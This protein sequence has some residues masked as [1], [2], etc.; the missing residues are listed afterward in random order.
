MAVQTFA[1][2]AHYER[3]PGERPY[4]LYLN[5]V[6][7]VA[8]LAVLLTHGTFLFSSTRLTRWVLPPIIFGWWGVDLFFV[9]S[10]F[11]ITGILLSTRAAPN[12]AT[13]FYAR[14]VLRIFPIYYLCLA[15]LWMVSAHSDW[16]GTMLP[17]SSAADRA[18]Y[19]FYFQNWIPLWHS[20]TLK[21][22]LLGHFWSLAVEEQFY[23]IWPWVVWKFSPKAIL[24][25]CVLGAVSALSL[26]IALV[27]HFGPHLWI[28]WLTVTR[29]EGLLVGSALAVLNSGHRRINPR[30]LVGM[31]L[32]GL[33]IIAATA[34]LDPAEFSNTDAGPYMYTICVSGLALVFGALIGGSQFRVPF[35]TPV[36]NAR[37]L[38]N[39]GKYSYGMYVYH[40]PLF[41]GIEHMM[42]K[43]LRF[44]GPIPNRYAFAELLLLIGATYVTAL[45]S[46]AL[47][48]RP[49][50][51]LKRYFV[52]QLPG[53]RPAA[54]RS[55]VAG[56]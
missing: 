54:T 51:S 24:G 39:L 19:L 11:L 27:S 17:Y 8:I 12:R 10:G 4:N 14:R 13:A 31:A 3:M 21:P 45:T 42:A 50:L 38:R 20:L 52:A 46:F 26:R 49:F 6:R 37:W 53:E 32:A 48:E 22:N 18:S 9:L 43:A 35:L 40:L 29:G 1:N 56:A 34:I 33:A 44:R 28:N 47:I 5:G 7:G 2:P 16:L 15:A 23:L 36:V 55:F 25:I 30:L 41:Y